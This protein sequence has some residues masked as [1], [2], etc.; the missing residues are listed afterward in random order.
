M[1]SVFVLLPR[2]NRG[3][4][5][6]NE[7]AFSPSDASSSLESGKAKNSRKARFSYPRGHSK[8]CHF[9]SDAIFS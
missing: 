9:F 6:C 8:E 3:G 4:T 1:V 7:F 2:Q 5:K